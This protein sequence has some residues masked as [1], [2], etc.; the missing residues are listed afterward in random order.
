MDKGSKTA[1][2]AVRRRGEFY[3]IRRV[4]VAWV[5][6]KGREREDDNAKIDLS[7]RNRV[8]KWRTPRRD[9]R[10]NGERRRVFVICADKMSHSVASASLGKVFAFH[11]DKFETSKERQQ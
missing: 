9:D 6:E 3:I 4:V 2:E 5:R 11:M 7:F 1:D 10:R 8:A